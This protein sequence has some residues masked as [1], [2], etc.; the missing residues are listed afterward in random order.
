MADMLEA[1]EL[2]AGEVRDFGERGV[3]LRIDHRG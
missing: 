1:T 3:L 2:V